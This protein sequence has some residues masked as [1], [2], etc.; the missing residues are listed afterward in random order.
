[1]TYVFFT[2]LCVFSQNPIF[3]VCG[4]WLCGPDGFRATTTRLGGFRALKKTVDERRVL[5]LTIFSSDC[6]VF[7][8][9][10]SLFRGA[11]YTTKVNYRGRTSRGTTLLPTYH[12]FSSDLS[13]VRR[14]G[15]L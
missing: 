3:I 15:L 11:L 13:L 4:V 9:Q 12:L 7:N 10:S 14:R 5:R 1:M 2:A 8:V 6:S